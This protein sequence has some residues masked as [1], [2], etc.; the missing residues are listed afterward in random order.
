MNFLLFGFLSVFKN[1][2]FYNGDCEKTGNGGLAPR[3]RSPTESM[4]RRPPGAATAAD[5]TGSTDFRGAAR[6][7]A[8]S[9][10]RNSG[11]TSG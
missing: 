8:A 11:T 4:G 5:S 9:F 2:L 1:S 6:E 3:A 7:E 10:Q